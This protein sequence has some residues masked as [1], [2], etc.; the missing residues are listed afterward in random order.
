M[1]LALTPEFDFALTLQGDGQGV[2]RMATAQAPLALDMA[3]VIAGAKGDMGARGEPG[4]AFVEANFSF[5]D[6]SP[7]P[8]YFTLTPT[9]IATVRLIIQTPFNGAGALIALGTAALPE[10]LMKVTDNAPTA[11]LEFESNPNVDLA[12]GQDVMLTIIPGTGA[13]QGH[14]KILL[15]LS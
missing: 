11:A 15:Q 10:L 13:T 3:A 2:L 7:T 12:T 14:G 6:A 8:I 4:S 1:Q 9:F 5:G